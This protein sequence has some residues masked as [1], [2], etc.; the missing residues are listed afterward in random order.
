MDEK[1]LKTADKIAWTLKSKRRYKN[2]S[3]DISVCR[4][5]GNRINIYFK[6]GCE[7][8]FATEDSKDIYIAIGYADD[9]MFITQTDARN[10]YAISYIKGSLVC[11]IPVK[12]ETEYDFLGKHKLLW[13]SE[14]QMY[15][16]EKEVG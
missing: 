4:G 5:S 14:F 12:S 1:I 15:Y 11:Q 2:E 7:K 9:C 10:G 3:S 13:D 8:Y 16:I 6:N